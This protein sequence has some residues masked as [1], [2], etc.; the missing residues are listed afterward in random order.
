MQLLAGGNE[1][2]SRRR[3]R[4]LLRISQRLNC[5]TR[6]RS[7]VTIGSIY[8]N[9]GDTF[10]RRAYRMSFI[11]FKVLYS[12]IKQALR[13]VMLFPKSTT[14]A[15]NGRIQL[16]S[17]LAMAIRF[18]AG[19][20][21]Y[22]IHALYSV[23]Y[24]EVFRSVD[25]VVDAVNS[26]PTFDISF[27]TNHDE[28]RKLAQEFESVSE[29]GIK[30]CCGCLDGLLIWT[31]Q[32]QKKDCEA[33]GVGCKQ[34]YCGRKYKYGLNM[35]GLCDRHLRFLDVSILFG[36]ATSDTLAF[37]LSS[38]KNKLNTPGFLAPGLYIFADNAYINSQHLATPFPNMSGTPALASK[39]SYNYYHSNL[40]IKIECA[41]GVLVQRFG[42]LRK[43][44]PRC[45]TLHK[46]IATTSCLCRLHNFLIDEALA[47][48][49]NTYNIPPP[50]NRDAFRMYRQ[51][52]V[53]LEHL[54][55]T[56]TQHAPQLANTGHHSSDHNRR[57]MLRDEAREATRR[58][59]QQPRDRI[60][61]D[62]LEE[63]LRRPR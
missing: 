30:G 37:E 46:I 8:R 44:A 51:G 40:R 14:N 53:P 39:D 32:P 23:S 34:F 13:A 3:K 1:E 56:D 11:T 4:K 29:G 61:D 2:L 5:P 6:K 45:Y 58:N 52:A 25:F 36:A 21:A 9:L 47:S 26:T 17:R 42:F 63:G 57:E 18:F 50:T 54:P 24:C 7:R 22:D 43:K 10:F 41:F 38:F 28:Q 33:I 15:P 59:A 27:P 35:Q 31:H 62:I 48:N 55:N 60:H 20:D 19:G 16:S 12:K 49:D